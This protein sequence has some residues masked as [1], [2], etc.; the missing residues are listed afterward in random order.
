MVSTYVFCKNF[1]FLLKTVATIDYVHSVVPKTYRNTFY[2]LQGD[3]FLRPFYNAV[4]VILTK[5]QMLFSWW[6]SKL[7]NNLVCNVGIR[8]E[9]EAFKLMKVLTLLVAAFQVSLFWLLY[10]L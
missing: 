1:A 7:P 9:I 5:M 2:E 8:I 3:V 10:G 4:T 6:S